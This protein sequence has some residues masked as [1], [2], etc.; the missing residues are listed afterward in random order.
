[1]DAA[2]HLIMLGQQ[3][4]MIEHVTGHSKARRLANTAVKHATAGLQLHNEGN[5]DGANAS[6]EK[7]AG[8]LRDAAII[9][10]GTIDKKRETPA[11]IILDVSELGSAQAAHQNYADA[12]N[13]GMKNGR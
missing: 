4:R 13:E 12:I 5:F 9:H 11:P 2:D 1:M 7:A 8:Y 6:A 3:A 10:A